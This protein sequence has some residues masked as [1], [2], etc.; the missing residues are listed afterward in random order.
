MSDV[1]VVITCFN[2]GRTVREAVES[3]GAQTRQPGELIVV[4]DGSS[5][6]HTRQALADLERGGICVIRTANHGVAAT[7]NLGVRLT[8]SPYIVLLDAD[9]LLEPTYLERLAGL[10]DERPDLDFV[11]CGLQAFGCA[12]YR[13]APPPC[14]IV[15]TLARGG[16]HVSSMF[17]RRLWDAVGGYEQLGGYE[18]LDFW[19]SALE[20]GCRGEPIDE[21]LLRYR[22]REGSRY[23][24]AIGRYVD[25]MAAIYARHRASVERFGPELLLAKDAFLLDQRAYRRELDRKRADLESRLLDVERQISSVRSRLGEMGIDAL[26]WGDFHRLAPLSSIWGLD[27]GRPLDRYYIEGFLDRHHLDIHGRVL[28]IKD[29]G[30]TRR[31]GGDRVVQSDV[32]DL[33]TSNPQ[34]TLIADLTKADSIPSN[35]FDCFVFTQTLHIIY[36]IRAALSHAFRILKPGGVLLCTLPVVSR[37]NY[38]NGGLD[39]GDFWRFTESSVRTL[40][41][42]FCPP[43]HFHVTVYGNVMAATGFLYGISP[44]ELEPA[45]LDHVDPWFPVIYG[46]RAVKPVAASVEAPETRGERLRIATVSATPPP[47]SAVLMYHRVSDLSPDSHRLCVPATDFRDQMLFVKR[48]YQPW[49]LTDLAAAAASGDAPSNGIAVTLDD[50][51][52]DGLTTA[53]PILQELGIP[54]TFFINTDRLSERH[55]R[56]W[57][58][59]ERIFLSGARLPD[60]LDLHDLAGWQRPARTAEDR[61]G[62]CQALTELIFP[63]S[64]EGRN[65]VLDRVGVWSGLDLTPRD[66][67]RPMVADEIRELST[68]SGL[69]VG[70]HTVHHL[71]L[72]YHSRAVQQQEISDCKVTLEQV[73]GRAVTS[74]SYPYGMLSKTTVEVAGAA[75]FDVAVTVE[76]RAIR[77]GCHRLLIPRV[78]IMRA[79]I[80]E[81]AALIGKTVGRGTVSGVGLGSDANRS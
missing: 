60:M 63:M 30:Y 61:A 68:R 52:L 41:A 33:D 79:P 29:A 27:R 81:F 10:L 20:A 53:A 78:E 31:F 58:I 56:H 43:E 51:Y 11:S 59:L 40:F 42:E 49:P 28:E 25:T 69:S 2:L 17:R 24:R 6:L 47:G 12:T 77:L 23:H 22:V 34:A 71:A 9:D 37:L 19:L 66:T 67:H 57:D 36:D 16:P 7:R 65:A 55:E 35:M 48:H 62:L 32:L 15:D 64:Q 75:G 38:E 72:P 73:T 18:V 13:W 5:D 3:A 4:D 44:D 54:A 70:C 21:P 1:A 26:D 74:F 45:E 8:S 14:T 80:D 46:V 76:G 50:G 39:G